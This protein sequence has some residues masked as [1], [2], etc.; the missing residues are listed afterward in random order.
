MLKF[1]YIVDG[2]REALGHAV[3]VFKGSN[4]GNVW[5]NDKSGSDELATTSTDANEI[6]RV[7]GEKY[8]SRF[9][10]QVTL[11]GEFDKGS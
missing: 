9:H 1:V 3:A 5:V 8:S 10:K 7:L 2:K 6:L 4:D 11:I